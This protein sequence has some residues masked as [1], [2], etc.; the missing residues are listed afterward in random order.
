MTEAPVRLPWHECLILAALVAGVT[1]A[2]ALSL[3]HDCL[4]G[5]PPV[6]RPDPGTPRASY[7][8]TTDI[9]HPGAIA[10]LGAAL[11]LVVAATTR[12]RSV[13]VVWFVVLLAAVAVILASLA[14]GLRAVSPL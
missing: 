1:L 6:E 12:R 2:M 11:V 5:P 7:C 9:G 3:H 10:L 4:H 8:A 14:A 13:T